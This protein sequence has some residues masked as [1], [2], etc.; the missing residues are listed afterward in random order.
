MQ[1]LRVCTSVLFIVNVTER[2][3]PPLVSPTVEGGEDMEEEE[4]SQLLS[5]DYARAEF[6]RDR[7]VP[8]AV[9]FFTG[10]VMEDE[11]ED[12]SETHQHPFSLPPSLLPTLS[13]SLPVSPPPPP[14]PP[15]SLPPSL[16]LPPSPSLPACLL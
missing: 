16:P 2:E 5:D 1:L 12:V 14:P 15:P 4:V 13:V 11:E 6:I 9:L 7:L 10:E 8:K 3:S